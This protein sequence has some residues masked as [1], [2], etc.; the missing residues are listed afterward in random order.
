[1]GRYALLQKLA[2]QSWIREG[3]RERILR[4]FLKPGNAAP[5]DFETDF[6]G[7][8][9]KGNLNS[10]IDW[11]V[12]FYGTYEKPA[13]MLLKDIAAKL[14]GDVVF[15]DIGA[16]VGVHSLFMSRY[17]GIV[18]SFEPYEAV[19]KRLEEKIADNGIK[20]IIVH[21]VALGKDE[22]ELPFYA[23]AGFNQG[24]GTFV[25]G[26]DAD[27]NYYAALKV[28]RGDRFFREKGI[29]KVNLIKIDVEGFEGKVL[30]GLGDVLKKNRPVVFMEFSER[31][32]QSFRSREDLLSALPE[33]YVMRN[34][35]TRSSH[36]KLTDFNFNM[37]CGDILLLPFEY[38]G[39]RLEK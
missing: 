25:S 7:Y 9:Y 36:Y 20:N 38:A 5:F 2:R 8:K 1:M 32:R 3:I 18:H 6:A 11:K 31:T 17:C 37:T 28:F 13:L 35:T 15:A 21:P 22:G 19:R 33:N 14:G 39:W 10:Y 24:A 16:N 26:H 30:A 4:F 12:Y 23:P 27:N 29:D 34:F